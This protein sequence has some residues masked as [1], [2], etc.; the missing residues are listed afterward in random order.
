MSFIDCDPI[1][2]FSCEGKE[3]AIKL[4][5]MGADTIVLCRNPEKAEA[6]LADIKRLSGSSKVRYGLPV[7]IG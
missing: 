3:T 4:A 7:F 1:L 6:A 5:S 2:C